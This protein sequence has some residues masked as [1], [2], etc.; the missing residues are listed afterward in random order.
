MFSSAFDFLLGLDFFGLL[1]VFWFY[2]LFELPRYTFSSIAVGYRA[3]FEPDPPL[4]PNEMPVS[5]LMVGHNE[6]RSLGRAVRA[7][8]EQTHTNLQIVVVEDG[9][10]DDMARVAARL[11]SEGLIHRFLSTGIRGGKAAALNLG[12]QLCDHEIIVVMDVDTSLD[13]DAVARVVAPLW[14][15]PSCGAVSGNLAV[16]NPD[17][18]LL[19]KFQAIEYISSISLGRQFNAMF[20]ILTIVSGA[21]GAYRRSAIRDVG[22]WDVGPGDDSNLTAKLR[23]AGW[24]VNFAPNAWAFTDVPNAHGAYLRQRLRWNRSIVR[25]RM[26]KYFVVFDPRQS[27]FTMRDVM[28]SLNVL[29]FQVALSFAWVAYIVNLFVEY[30]AMWILL[31]VAV[32]LLAIASDLVEFTIALI[33]LRRLPILRMLPYVFGFTFFVSYYD[34]AIRLVA[35]ISELTFRHSYADDFYPTKVRR[36]QDQ[37]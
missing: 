20:D 4:P 2:F 28:A 18:S 25:N 27:N 29:W 23:R 19:T 32:H 7:L 22:S 3:A 9:S 24:R 8:R 37:F 30:G 6:G 14:A 1:S 13:R 5:I 33:F 35:Y 11:K 17:Q 12:L 15:D 26:R 36:A 21:F 16:R 31:I 34:R 10:T